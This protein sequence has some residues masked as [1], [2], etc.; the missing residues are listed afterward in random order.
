MR[1]RSAKSVISPTSS[2]APVMA[3]PS[4]E[5]AAATSGSRLISSTLRDAD[6]AGG[7]ADADAPGALA[8]GGVELGG[9]SSDIWLL[10][11]DYRLMP[12]I[13]NQQRTT[14]IYVPE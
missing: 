11:P 5:T 2:F 14:F 6:S 13:S 4:R 7:T 1:S 3:S 9:V 10:V 8:A 12:S